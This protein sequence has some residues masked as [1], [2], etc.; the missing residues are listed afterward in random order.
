[1]SYFEL[2]QKFSQ[3]IFHKESILFSEDVNSSTESFAQLF[4]GY[5]HHDRFNSNFALISKPDITI[6]NIKTIK[7]GFDNLHMS[8]EILVGDTEKNS[9]YVSK[10]IQSG[11]SISNFDSYMAF[12]SSSKLPELEYDN[13]VVSVNESN[14]VDFVSVA[15]QVFDDQKYQDLIRS[16][17]FSDDVDHHNQSF[18]CYAEGEPVACGAV[19]ISKK[20]SLAYFHDCATLPDYRGRGFQKSLIKARIDYAKSFGSKYIYSCTSFGST[21]F[22]NYLKMGFCFAEQNYSLSKM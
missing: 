10:F 4:L 2:H 15:N 11:Y 5:S 12:E 13:E 6:Q 17:I 20:Y 18:V 8:P 21:S 1:M 16:F 7:T 3:N 22:Y 14:W 19:L 9:G